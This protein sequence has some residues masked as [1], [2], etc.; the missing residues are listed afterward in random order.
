MRGLRVFDAGVGGMMENSCLTYAR[1]ETCF[2]CLS[3]TALIPIAIDIDLGIGIGNTSIRH[4]YI[5]I[6]GTLAFV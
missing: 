4:I 2:P 3:Q 6:L 1:Q 5:Q